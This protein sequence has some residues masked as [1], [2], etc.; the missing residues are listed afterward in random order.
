MSEIEENGSLS[1][2]D[3]TITRKNNKFVTPVYLKSTFSDVLPNFERFL[4]DMHKRVL[5]ETLLHIGFRLYPS[6]ENFYREIFNIQA[7]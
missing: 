2:L 1:I 4:S 6:Y 3:I 7:P 5:I